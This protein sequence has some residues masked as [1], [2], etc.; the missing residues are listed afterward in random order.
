MEGWFPLQY[1]GFCQWFRYF[2]DRVKCTQ[3][4]KIKLSVLLLLFKQYGSQSQKM[5][6]FR[7]L[8]IKDIS[9][10][11]LRIPPPKL[12]DKSCQYRKEDHKNLIMYMYL[13]EY[14]LLLKKSR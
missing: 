14:N 10:M 4:A 3:V 2:S 9:G 11:N 1:M 12:L 13:K 8:T 6:F 7:L 5:V